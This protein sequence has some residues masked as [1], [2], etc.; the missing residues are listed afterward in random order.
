MRL[1]GA[2]LKVRARRLHVDQEERGA[3]DRLDEHEHHV[4]VLGEGDEHLLRVQYPV[5]SFAPGRAFELRHVSAAVRLGGGD[6]E[7]PQGA[8]G[9]GRQDA[10]HAARSVP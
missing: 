9:D 7:A 6:R 2:N 5:V 3:A 10:R 8:V 1:D 4:R